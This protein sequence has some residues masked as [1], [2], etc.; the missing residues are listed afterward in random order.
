M[1]SLKSLVLRYFVGIFGIILLVGAILKYK[2]YTSTIHF[3]EEQ[4]FE[5]AQS[6]A[7]NL[8][9]TILFDSKDDFLQL[10]KGLIRDQ[11][12][13]GI[14]VVVNDKTFASIGEDEL[15]K[16]PQRNKYWVRDNFIVSTPITSDNK[17]IGTLLIAF[18]GED[19]FTL[20]RNQI[21]YES[22]GVLS[23]FLLLLLFFKRAQ[24][25]FIYP[26]SDL[27]KTIEKIIDENDLSV[28]IDKT[29]DL[30][31]LEGLRLSF[32]N[33]LQSL[34]KN[35]EDLIEL[36]NNQEK[37]I[38]D[39]TNDLIV[40]LEDLKSSQEQIVAQEK[41]ASLGSLTAGIAH[42]IKNP[43]NLLSNSAEI[44]EKTLT[45]KIIPLI[46][47]IKTGQWDESKQEKV[48]KGLKQ[49]SSASKIIKENS[50]KS[51]GIV[52]SML[53]LAREGETEKTRT[54]LKPI[55]K[56]ALTFILHAHKSKNQSIDVKFI[57]NLEDN[58]FFEC[59]ANDFERVF[60]NLLENSLYA[61]KKKIKDDPNFEAKIWLRGYARD[62]EL[63]LKFRDNG[64]GIPPEVKEKILLPFFTT[65]PPGEGTGLGISMVSDIVAGHKGKIS[66]DSQQGEYTEITLRFP[67][68]NLSL[69]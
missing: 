66:I 64:I 41:L 68:Q 50:L 48:E 10:T 26:L 1:I 58:L 52:K 62:G 65:K 42:E 19:I 17:E 25:S 53:L 43:M 69:N 3:F 24:N 15:F 7:V 67:L 18:S 37:V 61:L 54:D 39:R 34:N 47:D 8:E 13:K 51:D 32:N 11:H 60:I 36:N 49:L 40:A 4:V 38:K 2:E 23:I 29:S 44:M 22:L 55:L 14:R 59:Q 5:N 16:S 28:Q 35:R 33:L 45:T 46:D 63:L 57:E 12:Y 9:S 6:L 21:F 20:F 30:Q 56:N 31:E 27:K